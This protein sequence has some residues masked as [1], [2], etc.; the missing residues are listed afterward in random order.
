ME[1]FNN[2]KKLFRTAFLFF[3]VLTL[4]V[5]VLPALNNQKNNR[6]LPGAEPLSA[7]AIKGKNLYISNGCVAC[8]TQQVRNLDMDKSFGSRPGIAADYAG[9]H[10]T[11]LWRNTATLM[12]TERTG[13]DL[14]DVGNRQPSRDWNLVHLFNPRTVVKESIMPSYP[15]LFTIKEQ[16]EKGDVVVNVPKEFMNGREGKVVATQDALYLI[17]YLQSLKQTKLPDG[18]PSPDFLYKRE[19]KQAGTAAATTEPDGASL[20]TANCQS[21]HLPNGEGLPG[22]FPPLKGSEVV[23]G[24]NLE[25]YVSIIMNGYDARADYGVMPAVGSAANFSAAEVTAIINHER[26]AWGNN[27]KKVTQEEIQKIMD[28]VKT[29]VQE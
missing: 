26:T 3:A 10:R 28:F 19:Q 27:G 29:Q 25:L 16:P 7:D 13:P 9:I 4:L 23:N 6:P 14:T 11:D 2:H 20:Y 21:C 12:G 24:D 18:T 8:H 1:F 5:A 22:A 15:W 17:A